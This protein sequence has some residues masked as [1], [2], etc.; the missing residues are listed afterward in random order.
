MS[1]KLNVKDMVYSALFATLTAVLSYVTIPLPFSPIPITAQSLAVMLAGCVLTPL[2]A[3]LSMI[4]FLLMGAIGLPVF[5]GG[6]AGFGIIVGKT[7]GY[8]IG[9]LIGAVVISLLVSKTKSKVVMLLACLFGGIVVVH[10]LGSAW[11]GYVTGMGIEKAI[12]V[13]SVPFLPGDLLKSFAAVVIA[14]RLN[15]GIVKYVQA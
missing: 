1:K 10:A 15:K 2:Q 9:Y 12:M 14:V 5:S 8:L 3:A 13:G 7:G 4:T 11:L 6:S